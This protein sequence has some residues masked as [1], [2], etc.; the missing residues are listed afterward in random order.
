MDAKAAE[1]A[2]LMLASL[3]KS[4]TNVSLN[5]KLISAMSA[6]GTT[7][8]GFEHRFRNIKKRAKELVDESACGRGYRHAS[9]EARTSTKK[10]MVKDEASGD[11][12][13]VQ[14]PASKSKG[15]QKA[16]GTIKH[17]DASSGGETAVDYSDIDAQLF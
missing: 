15:K 9:Q 16:A 13:T 17:E 8:S 2:S 5:Y 11:D 6:D 4:G 7:P 14:E 10:N 3:M 1:L 12:G